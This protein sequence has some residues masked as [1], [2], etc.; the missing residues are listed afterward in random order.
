[1]NFSLFYMAGIPIEKEYEIIALI[2][3]NLG[4]KK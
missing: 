3:N 2:F 4:I 1:M